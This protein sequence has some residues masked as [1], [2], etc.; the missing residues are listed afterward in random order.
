[1]ASSKE[2][3]DFL[4]DLLEAIYADLPSP[5]GKRRNDKAFITGAEVCSP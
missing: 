1:M 3:R 2:Y 5:P 4:Q